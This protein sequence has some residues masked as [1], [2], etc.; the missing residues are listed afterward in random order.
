MSCRTALANK[1]AVLSETPYGSH[2][3]AK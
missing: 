1:V 3:I 2:S